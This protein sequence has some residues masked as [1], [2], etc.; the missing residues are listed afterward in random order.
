VAEGF[1]EHQD[2]FESAC[3]FC[4]VALAIASKGVGLQLNANVIFVIAVIAM[5]CG[6]VE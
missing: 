4:Y 6:I 5:P 1:Y 3:L 2:T